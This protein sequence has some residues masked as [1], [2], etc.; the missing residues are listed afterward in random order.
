MIS[1]SSLDRMRC[2]IKEPVPMILARDIMVIS[3]TTRFGMS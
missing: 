1:S 2:G 3:K